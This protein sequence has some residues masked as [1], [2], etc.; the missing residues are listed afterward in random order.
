VN[1]FLNEALKEAIKA[2]KKNE[3]P[4][5][6]VVVKNG[7]VIARA[8]NLRET[9]QDPLT[10]AEL[11][12]ISKAAKKVG[13]WRLV[14]CEVYVTLEPCVMCAGALSQARVKAVFYGALDP[15]GG[16]QSLKVRIHD[17]P[18]MN[19]RYD[20]VHLPSAECGQILSEFF[21]KKRKERKSK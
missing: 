8:H 12:A 11:I 13:S 15:K 17:N 3:V 16:A 14:D 6:A 4:V 9:R 7:R 19:H 20:L 2:E 10:H 1:L 21:K 18:K 5:G